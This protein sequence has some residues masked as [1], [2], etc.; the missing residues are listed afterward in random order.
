MIRQ[1]LVEPDTTREVRV[2][3]QETGEVVFDQEGAVVMELIPMVSKQALEEAML[4]AAAVLRVAGG[5]LNVVVGRE[6]TDLE[7]E[8][9]VNGAVLRWGDRTDAK[10]SREQ[11]MSATG[12][13]SSPNVEQAL[14][15]VLARANALDPALA[16]HL[17]TGEG[18]ELE[19]EGSEPDPEPPVELEGA[20]TPAP[21]AVGPGDDV[22]GTTNAE[23]T[24]S[25]PVGAV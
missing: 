20:A 17:L 8:M 25:I 11:P 21:V 4:E 13:T 19:G 10:A 23:D 3:D 24:S 2:R 16:H 15:T 9:V 5:V 12:E 6:R 22:P 7:H 14:Q 1:W 18:L